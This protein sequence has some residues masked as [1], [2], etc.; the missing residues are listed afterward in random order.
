MARAPRWAE[1][2]DVYSASGNATDAAVCWMNAVWE[3]PAP[4][5]SWLE[6]WFAA[7]CRAAKFTDQ[8]GGLDRW[9]SETGRPGAARVVAAYTAWAGFSPTPPA[10]FPAAL[11][12]ILVYLDQHFDDLPV[13]AAWLARR[14]ATQLCDGDVLGL[15]RWHD[16]V[17]ARLADRGPGLDLDE[18]S[19][20]R[21]HGTA[22]ADRFET[23]R[24][25]LVR[26]RDPAVA[27]VQRHGNG[28]R[29]RSVGLD[30]ETE[31]TAAY[32]QF[33]LAWGLGCLGE[34]TLARDWAA[35]A[36]KRLAR[37]SGPGIDPAAHAL[38]SDLFLHRVKDAQEGRPAK[39]GL[40]A[41]LHVRL[42]TLASLTRYSVD[43]LRE[44][45]RILEPLDRVRAYR[46]VQLK[47]SGAMTSSPSA[48]SVLPSA[49]TPPT[50]PMNATLS[51]GCARRTP[52][53]RPCRESS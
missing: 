27:W 33:M 5:L 13:R 47:V 42:D 14:A 31:A 29:L 40:P 49:L 48:S 3:A 10:E 38:L 22:S 28:G 17:L 26:M 11:A 35:R 36:R 37:Y 20:L 7:E 18:P 34:R 12:R 2:A 45:S 16:R 25:W 51:F 9:L 15:A 23:A 50:W 1:L 32:A 21:F 19:F 6:Q 24:E 43:R 30:A 44:H 41:D 8:S 53:P 46:G 4:A 52:A 39:L